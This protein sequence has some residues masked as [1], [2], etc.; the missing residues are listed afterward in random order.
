MVDMAAI[1]G[2]ASALKS[3]LDIAKA[4]LGMHDAALIRAKV[5][6]MQGEISTALASAITAQT[7]QLAMLN[8][9]NDLEKEVADLKAWDAEKQNY[10][11]KDLCAGSGSMAYV[12]KPDAQGSEPI[13]CLCAKCYQ[14][15]K[16]RF[17]QNTGERAPGAYGRLWR[18]PECG[19]P[20]NVRGW[21]PGFDPA[22]AITNPG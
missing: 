8:R 5:T 9:V 3:A 10:E 7:D 6:E 18:C 2:A 1:A 4:A 11:L 20:I 21:P 14:E 17:L 16:K 13:H 12:I 19:S 22:A 15:G